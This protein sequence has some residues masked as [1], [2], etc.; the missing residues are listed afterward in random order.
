MELQGRGRNYVPNDEGGK[1]K[2]EKKEFMIANGEKLN[3]GDINQEL[4]DEPTE[5]DYVDTKDT[6]KYG[7]PLQHDPN[8]KGPIKNR[9]CTDIICCLLF[10]IFIAGLAVVAYFAFRYGDPRLLIYPVNSDNEVCGYGKQVGKP[11]L[12]FFDMIECGRMGVGVFVNG[13][14]TPQVCVSECP[15][16][17]WVY[18]DTISTASDL[19]FCKDSINPAT[20]SKSVLNLVK[21]E[22]C[23]RY[24]LKSKSLINRCVPEILI[25]ALEGAVSLAE[26]LSNS[27]VN[28][29]SSS[30][31][32][33][34]ASEIESGLDIYGTFLKAKEYA[35]KIIEDVV[36]AWWMILIGLVLSMIFAFIWIVIMRW[37]AGIMV[38]FT[39]FAFIGL[40]GFAAAWSFYQY[41]DVKG[42]SDSFY[43]QFVVLQMNLSKEKLYLAFGIIAAVILAIA[44]LILLILCGRIRI[45]ISLIKEGSKAIGNMMFTL[46]FPIFPF[47]LQILVIGSW[48]TIAVFLASTGRNQSFDVN[49]NN[50]EYYNATSGTWNFDSIKSSTSQFFGEACDASSS[51]AGNTTASNEFCTFLKSQEENFTFYTQIYALFMLF[52][53]VNFVVALG[54][55]TLAGAFASYYWAFNKPKDIPAFPLLG[56]FWRCFRYHL[57]SL[58][59]G[60]LIIAI[61]QIIR[62]ML[63]YVDHKLKGSENAVAKFFLKC[64]KCCFWCLEKFLKFLNKNAYIL[65][66]AHG[67][68]FCTSAK[69]AFMLIMRNIVRVVVVDKVADFLLLIGKLVV[70]AFAASTSFFFFDGR[71]EF[72]ASFTPSLNFYV[73]PIVLV[74]IGAYVIASCFFSVYGMA[75]DTLFLCF[76]EDLERND[77]SAEK[78]YFMSKDLLKILGKKNVLTDKKAAKKNDF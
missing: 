38:W 17:N 50:S 76:L 18:I 71:I 23:A 61:V 54:Q 65:I 12:H 31:S 4:D 40:F 46:L 64:L 29:T 22:D 75:V 15:T 19:K 9:S 24:T 48:L 32:D 74:T 49:K 36:T 47:V 69:N 7:T 53:L 16:E 30:G 73:V 55:M 70:V 28:A 41:M 5:Y 8:Y 3:L 39:I 13:C 60:S 43:I 44:L 37:I 34:S 10:I 45:A 33:Y 72:L 6:S 25:T 58:A 51:V 27:N 2:G 20:S 67:K 59:F 11:Y 42:S 21:D 63:E 62:V 57:G 1:K 78:P 66:A 52:W 14:P 35:E 26:G 68:N 56:S 77:G